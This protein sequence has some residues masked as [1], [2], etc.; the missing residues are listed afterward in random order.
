MCPAVIVGGFGDPKSAC[1]TSVGSLSI[2]PISSEPNK[3]AVFSLPSVLSSSLL[4]CYLEPQLFVE[5]CAKNLEIKRGF[6]Y[7]LQI[8]AIGLLPSAVQAC[9]VLWCAAADSLGGKRAVTKI[10]SVFDGSLRSPKQFLTVSRK[11][12]LCYRYLYRRTR[13]KGWAE[14][15]AAVMCDAS[16]ID[17]KQGVPLVTFVFPEWTNLSCSTQIATDLVVRKFFYR[18]SLQ[19][20]LSVSELCPFQL[21]EMLLITCQL[22]LNCTNLHSATKTWKT[23][24]TNCSLW[25]F[26]K[27]II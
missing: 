17:E 2:L 27:D 21:S 6:A 13:E 9:A 20:Y 26:G 14:I 24:F 12:K 19:T 3:S 5:S 8:S 25:D 10:L 23:N 18:I 1:N 7:L 22:I 15:A 16:V 11:H 4:I